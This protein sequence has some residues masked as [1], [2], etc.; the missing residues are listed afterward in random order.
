MVM[1]ISVTDKLQKG[2]LNITQKEN[3]ADA[4]KELLKRELIRKRNKYLYMIKTFE[5]KH[6]MEFNDFEKAYKNRKM[7]YVT[8]KDYFDWDMAVTVLED[9]EEEFREIL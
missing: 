9:V 2:L 6:N 1:N 4:I 3:A 7:D 5:K 8:E